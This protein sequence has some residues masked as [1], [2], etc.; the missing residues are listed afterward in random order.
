MFAS[1][2]AVMLVKEDAAVYVIFSPCSSVSRRRTGGTPL[3]LGAFALLYFALALVW[4]QAAGEGAMFGRYDNL[5]GEDGLL[6][7]PKTLL[8]S[9]GFFLTQLFHTSS[10]DSGKWLYLFQLLVPLAGCR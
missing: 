2:L 4:L 10:G 1:A 9:P 6:S 3:S 7:L 8:R 5:T